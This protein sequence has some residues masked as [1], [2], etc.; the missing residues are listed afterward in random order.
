[1]LLRCLLDAV[2]EDGA[3][4][5]A[6]LTLAFRDFYADR[7]ARG[8]PVEKPRAR[9]ARVA[10]LSESEIQRLILEMPFRKFAQRGF[11]DYCRDISRVQF[12]PTL[13]KRANNG[14]RQRLR[15]ISQEA[16]ECYYAAVRPNSG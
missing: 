13:W 3:V 16:I 14:D 12:A 5:I 6:A 11:L 10:D 1:M 8:L 2:D 9:M 7:H 4:L 15:D